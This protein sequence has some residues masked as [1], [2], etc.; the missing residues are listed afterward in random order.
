MAGAV[1]KFEGGY[2]GIERCEDPDDGKQYLRAVIHSGSTGRTASAP[3]DI[4]N[5]EQFAFEILRECA[6][7]RGYTDEDDMRMAVG[8]VFGLVL[9]GAG[10]ISKHKG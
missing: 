5:V 6:L 7:G 8:S 4:E 3:I 10:I 2:L 9:P 1:L